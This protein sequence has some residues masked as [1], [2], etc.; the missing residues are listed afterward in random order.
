MDRFRRPPR[1][2][3][4]HP[5]GIVVDW[6]RHIRRRGAI[7]V[8]VVAH[9]HHHHRI[10]VRRR[11]RRRR[12]EKRTSLSFYGGRRKGAA[13]KAA[14][15]RSGGTIIGATRR[16]DDDEC[17]VLLWCALL[18]AMAFP[19]WCLLFFLTQT[20]N[21]QQGVKKSPVTK[22]LLEHKCDYKRQKQKVLEEE[23]E[24][25]KKPQN[26]E[27]TSNSRVFSRGIPNEKTRVSL[28]AFFL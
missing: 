25:K 27:R 4:L 18:H 12:R 11:R 10:I 7:H 19:E 26:D 28:R 24:D 6:T 21:F 16:H 23:E 1:L 22:G 20:L 8:V 5:H 14:R 9:H 15:E 17:E 13:Q 2:D 3:L